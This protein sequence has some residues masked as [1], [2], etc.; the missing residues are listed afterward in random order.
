MARNIWVYDYFLKDHLGNTRVITD[1][2]NLSS[3]TLE[4]YSYYPFGLQQKRIGVQQ[5]TEPQHNKYTYNGK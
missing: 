5:T 3:P 1:D 2:Y 4:A